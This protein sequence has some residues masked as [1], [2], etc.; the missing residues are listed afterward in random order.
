[1][2]HEVD[3]LILA[4]PWIGIWL[5]IFVA[6]LMSSVLFVWW[7]TTARIALIATLFTVPLG[8]VI[9]ELTHNIHLLGL[10]HFICFV[11]LLWYTYHHERFDAQSLH[12]VYGIWLSLM[13]LV[14]TI[15]F[16][17]DARD[18]FMVCLGL[19]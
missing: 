15:S 6:V 17:F 16:I 3:L 2:Q 12:T 5:N 14:I 4:S 13:V 9:F 19:K 11:P 8:Y 10:G 1:M 7:H 18:I